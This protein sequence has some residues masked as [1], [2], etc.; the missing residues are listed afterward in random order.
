[1]SYRRRNI[2]YTVV[3]LL[4]VFAVYLYRTSRTATQVTI[5]GATMGTTYHITYFDDQKRDLKSQVD[6]LLEI[7]NQ[8]LNTY[9]PHSE[10]SRFNE[11]SYSFR[12]NLPYFLPVL[13]RSKEIVDASRG[14]FDPTVMPL[15]NAWGFGPANDSSRDSTSIDSIR[16]F[17]G[18]DKIIFNDDSLWKTDSRTQL[19]FSAIAKGYGVDVVA[20]FIHSKGIE[21]LLVEIGGEVVAKG[22]NLRTNHNWQLG[23]LDPTSTPEDRKLFAY[24][25]LKDQG[26]AT[27][28][29]Y[30]NYREV[31]GIKVS[32]TIDPKSGY[33]VQ[34]NLLSAT[35][36]ANDCM[37][38]DAWA[39]AF[40]V[41]GVEQAKKILD[42]RKELNAFLIY[43]GDDGS[44]QSFVTPN[45]AELTMNN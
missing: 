38:A 15:V 22:I 6:S 8:C 45:L 10:I 31:N 24:V 39:T 42:E 11:E 25:P 37:T 18:F 29:N 33:S 28:G 20:D 35:V 30:F 9:L 36:F 4:A 41:M 44:I 19:D 7:Y 3:L 5:E 21:N 26:M 17:V 27:S 2:I 12:F 23:I 34:H 1:M 13:R 40:M 32:H 16:A 14:A 43:S